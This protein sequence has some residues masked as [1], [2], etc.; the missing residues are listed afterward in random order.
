M[1]LL[2]DRSKLR[3]LVFVIALAVALAGKH[4]RLGNGGYWP[5][6]VA[7]LTSAQRR[8]IVLSRIR[9]GMLLS[10]EAKHNV[11]AAE[12][13]CGIWES[14]LSRP[15]SSSSSS[16]I[17]QDVLSLSKTLYASCL[18]RVGRDAEAV[19]VYESCLCGTKHDSEN[20]WRLAKARCLQRLLRY[21]D[22]A[23]E[24]TRVV[25]DADASDCAASEVQ[26]ARM[27]AATC[28]LRGIG[29]VVRAREVLVSATKDVPGGAE[30]LMLSVCLE[31]LETGDE[32]RAVRM[33]QK[34]LL[35]IEENNGND[36]DKNNNTETPTM[37]VFYRWILTALERNQCRNNHPENQESSPSLESA[38]QVTPIKR[39]FEAR[40]LFMEL[41]RIN[42]SPLDDP[43]LYRLDDKIELHNLLTRATTEEESQRIIGDL[44]TS[45][46]SYWPDGFVLPA[47]ASNLKENR[48]ND[49]ELWISKSRAGYG[50]H[51][52]RIATLAEARE[53]LNAVI[54]N[55]DE[56]TKEE[57]DEE[58]YLLQRMVDPLVLLQGYKFSLRIYVVYFSPD[59]AYI[60]TRG[61]VK[62]ASTQ[63]QMEHTDDHRDA[64][65]H[66]TNSGRETV[67]RQEN[68]EY[69]WKELD[70]DA[71]REELWRDI[72]HVAADT[73]LYRYPLQTASLG[74]DRHS[75]REV[76]ARR[77][78]SWGIPKILGLDFVVREEEENNDTD[79]QG[80]R[81][82]TTPWLVEVNRFP[83]LEPRDEDDRKIKYKVVRDAWKKAWERL[84]LV[85]NEGNGRFGFDGSIFDSLCDDTE[86]S[87]ERLQLNARK[88]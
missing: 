5:H 4:C 88:Q 43:D 30:E 86:S 67:M 26:Q 81:R 72:C 28:I 7:A 59:E 56:P 31:Y 50:S 23:T 62:L 79:H 80:Q 20:Q 9:K 37:F 36:S 24:Y 52:N 65:M 39:N 66:M 63:L 77:R 74:V 10:Q 71:P 45:S 60:S 58:P 78:E 13:A 21:S 85:A 2:L 11:T 19:N 68:L 82:T 76:W 14:V 33:L 35:A 22:A 51:G 54:K 73:L 17:T 18:V 55:A 27:G 53:E 46:T 12:E 44:V 32:R 25:S 57:T 70:G 64:S 83:G 87:L 40:Y 3:T 8:A 1:H 61:L 29:D 49:S 15:S 42:T 16:L 41:I 69:L 47:E 75:T 84:D 34:N 38:E 6:V 48:S